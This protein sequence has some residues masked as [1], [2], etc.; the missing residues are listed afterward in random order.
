MENDVV[1]SSCNVCMYSDPVINMENDVVLSCRNVCMYSDTV[2]NMENDVVLS[3]R[4]VYMLNTTLKCRF[5]KCFILFLYLTMMT[6][7]QKVHIS[8]DHL[9]DKAPNTSY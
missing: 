1:L 9:F 5:N 7:R 6:Y 4:N 3:C 8:D 2:I